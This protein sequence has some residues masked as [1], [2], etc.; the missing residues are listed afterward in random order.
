M[1][2]PLGWPANFGGTLQAL[3]RFSAAQFRPKIYSTD[4]RF[5]L[6]KSLWF[7]R[8]PISNLNILLPC[9]HPHHHFFIAPLPTHTSSQGPVAGWVCVSAMRKCCFFSVLTPT[10][11]NNTEPPLLAIHR[12]YKGIRKNQP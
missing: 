6:L 3:T 2:L 5:E 4:K 8:A 11:R 1:S 7:Q 12:V 10:R 9:F